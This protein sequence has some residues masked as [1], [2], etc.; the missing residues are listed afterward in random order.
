M[1]YVVPIWTGKDGKETDMKIKNMRDFM[2]KLETFENMCQITRKSLTEFLETCK[3]YIDFNMNIE[4]ERDFNAIQFYSE[5]DTVNITFVFHSD[6]T[7]M[8]VAGSWGKETIAKSYELYGKSSASIR[9][10]FAGKK[11][12]RVAKEL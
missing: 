12:S 11:S 10:H 3:G 8:S 1:K 4:Y 9:K 7:K 2:I 6:N 5:C